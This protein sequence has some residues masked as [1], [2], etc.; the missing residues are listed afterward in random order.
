MTNRYNQ[1]VLNIRRTAKQA[2]TQ[3]FVVD[4]GGDLGGSLPMAVPSV[5]RPPVSSGSPSYPLMSPGSTEPAR[6]LELETEGNTPGMRTLLCCWRVTSQ[7]EVRNRRVAFK[8][9]AAHEL[10]GHHDYPSH[11]VR[12]DH[13]RPSRTR[14]IANNGK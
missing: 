3:G 4:A 14:T 13:R 8:R 9:P 2:A 7:L 10:S 6:T 1:L 12:H 5:G 11:D